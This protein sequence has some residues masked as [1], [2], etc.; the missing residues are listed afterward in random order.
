MTEIEE[1]DRIVYFV[2]NKTA[3]I[4][5][6][7]ETLTI[8]NNDDVSAAIELLERTK[9]LLRKLSEEKKKT[10]KPHKSN[11]ILSQMSKPLQEITDQLSNKI[12]SFVDNAAKADFSDKNLPVV[13]EQPDLGNSYIKESW[14]FEIED[15]EIVPMGFVK[16]IPD[17]TKI[18]AQIRKGVRNIPGIKIFKKRQLITRVK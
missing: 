4:Q 3:Q 15:I 13:F 9:K 2:K 14:S 17:T 1:V 12:L 16:T 7:T 10:Q 5:G 18:N 6:L 11:K 8:K